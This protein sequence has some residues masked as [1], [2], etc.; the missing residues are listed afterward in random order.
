[1]Q[2]FAALDALL[3]EHPEWADKVTGMMINQTGSEEGIAFCTD[4]LDLVLVQDNEFAMMWIG[5]GAEYNALT[6]VDHYGVLAQKFSNV[7]FENDGPE[8]VALVNALLE[9]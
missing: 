1:M 6:V 2:Q 3:K 7:S 9:L 8:V 5:L 4:T